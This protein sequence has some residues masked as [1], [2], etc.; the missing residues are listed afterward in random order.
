MR[1]TLSRIPVFQT[2]VSTIEI[3]CKI[4]RQVVVCRIL[5]NCGDKLELKSGLYARLVV[6]NHFLRQQALQGLRLREETIATT[7]P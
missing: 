5:F 1:S 7:V 6:L 3:I 2:S 4:L